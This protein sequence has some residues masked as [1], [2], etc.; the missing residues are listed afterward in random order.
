MPEEIAAGIFCI[1]LPLPSTGL[2]SVNVYALQNDSDFLLIDCGWNTPE[3]HEVLARELKALG[4][5]IE[6]IKQIVVTH[7]HPDHFGL[8]G[9]IAEESGA[10]VMMHRL[11]AMYVSARYGDTHDLLSE[12][13][14]W[15]R[16]NGVSGDELAA[17]TDASIRM[18]EH[19]NRRPPDRLLEGGE[20]LE[21]GELRLQV[22]WTPGHSS[23]LICLYEPRLQVLFSNDH[24]LPR[25]SPHVG[26]HVQSIGNP[27]R[28]FLQ[29]LHAVRGLPVRHVLPG[30]GTPF[31]DL[32]GRIDELI[33][34]HE[35]RLDVMRAVL[36]QEMTAYDVAARI[37]WRGSETGWFTL[38]PFQRRMALTETIAHLEYLYGAGRVE[39]QF[40]NGV[41]YYDR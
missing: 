39:K 34:H 1:V 13:D 17:M 12:M 24:V 23:G 5:G 33:Q 16:T 37:S 31:E 35:E 29:S 41:V 21:W 25:I 8:A 26:L 18:L 32:P 20:V 19:V 38:A 40:K 9:R 11:D 28:D 15:L 10:A 27:L 7:I 3:A 30:H 22:L 6:R 4:R 14:A 36:T 2:G